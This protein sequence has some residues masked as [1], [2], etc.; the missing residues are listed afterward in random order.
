MSILEIFS[1]KRS[2]SRRPT[3]CGEAIIAHKRA[4]TG[5]CIIGVGVRLEEDGPPARYIK[6]ERPAIIELS[7]ELLQS[8][9]RGG[10][11]RNR[12]KMTDYFHGYAI[13]GVR[14]Y[15]HHLDEAT[16]RR[17]SDAK[18]TFTRFVGVQL[19]VEWAG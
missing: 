5:T 6:L 1:R 10:I 11:F 7:D 18:I 4:N 2:T 8:Y 19:G 16:R 3:L 15:H 9:K 14:N 12:W 13:D 17:L